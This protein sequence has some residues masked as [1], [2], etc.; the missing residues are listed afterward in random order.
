MLIV[1][2]TSEFSEFH[3]IPTAPELPLVAG[4]MYHLYHVSSFTNP[5]T[6]QTTSRTRTCSSHQSGQTIIVQTIFVISFYGTMFVGEV[7]I[8]LWRFSWFSPHILLVKSPSVI[9]E[10][11]C[12]L[13][14][15]FLMVKSPSMYGIN[16]IKAP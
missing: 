14:S 2:C 3:F 8:L 16:V 10:F 12:L 5:S 11:P 1:S 4:S 7:P 15:P 9:V 13:V 6:N